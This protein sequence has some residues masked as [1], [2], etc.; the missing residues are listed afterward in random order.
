[1]K[2]LTISILITLI[3]MFGLIT[4]VS[5]QG[6]TCI[7]FSVTYD[8]EDGTAQGWE[9]YY[10]SGWNVANDNRCIG[11]YCLIADNATAP[12]TQ[13]IIDNLASDIGTSPGFP[14]KIDYITATVRTDNLFSYFWIDAA[15]GSTCRFWNNQDI[16]ATID[17]WE[18]ITADCTAHDWDALPWQL[19]IQIWGSNS[20]PAEI[21][22]LMDDI[23][24]TGCYDD[25]Q[26][27]LVVTFFETMPKVQAFTWTNSITNPLPGFEIDWDIP[28]VSSYALAVYGLLEQW[29]IFET[30]FILII[31]VGLFRWLYGYATKRTG[32][33]PEN[34]IDLSDLIDDDLRSEIGTARRRFK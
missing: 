29:Q 14:I 7:P 34:S 28:L 2:R 13:L 18:T 15:V 1:M 25:P 30:L 12:A 17:N 33:D 9:N 21:D 16:P 27:D 3:L 22:Y 10:Y 24:I 8:F 23:T 4:G 6:P 19:Y 5:A 20:A 11:S 32:P 26:Y 31:A